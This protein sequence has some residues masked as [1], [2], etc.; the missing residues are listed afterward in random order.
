MIYRNCIMQETYFNLP[1]QINAEYMRKI[2]SEKLQD[3][4]LYELRKIITRKINEVVSNYND[5]NFNFVDIDIK[6][7]NYNQNSIID[8]ELVER[9]FK[10][11]Y[12]WL[13]KR[14][15]SERLAKFKDF[16]PCGDMP[17]RLR[18]KW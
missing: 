5:T 18:I 9:G 3:V 6:G 12:Y 16:G 10:L 13:D 7:N 14:T 4:R 17:V 11:D 2:R 15:G 8:G 1:L